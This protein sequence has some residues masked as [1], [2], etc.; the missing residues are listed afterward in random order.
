MYSVRICISIYRIQICI[1]IFLYIASACN[2]LSLQH[3]LVSYSTYPVL[4]SLSYLLFSSLLYSLCL[5][6]TSWRWPGS[7][8]AS[9]AGK[10]S[11][12]PSR[13]SCSRRKSGARTFTRPGEWCEKCSYFL[14]MRWRVYV[15]VVIVNGLVHVI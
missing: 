14:L 15:S 10:S 13:T 3:N 11:V 8:W 5:W 12:S 7:E 6:R 9:P 1:C 2:Y 4:P